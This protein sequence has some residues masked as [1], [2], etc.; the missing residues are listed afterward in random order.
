MLNGDV[1]PPI[2]EQGSVGASG[3]LGITERLPVHAPIVPS[4][5]ARQ[6]HQ[7]LPKARPIDALGR[8][9]AQFVRM[10]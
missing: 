6:V 4:T 7:A 1:Y 10:I 5:K 3:D 2:P 9:H 8:P